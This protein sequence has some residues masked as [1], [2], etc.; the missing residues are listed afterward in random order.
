MTHVNASHW[1]N[2]SE[3]RQRTDLVVVD[4]AVPGD[5]DALLD[6]RL[7]QAAFQRLRIKNRR[8]DGGCAAEPTGS[9]GLR[10]CTLV[11]CV[12]VV[13][14]RDSDV[15]VWAVIKTPGSPSP[16]PSN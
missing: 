6:P 5:D 15:I 8:G 13:V 4:V 9:A 14:H 12:V 2:G 3:S 1:P 7:R 10:V 11:M 16:L